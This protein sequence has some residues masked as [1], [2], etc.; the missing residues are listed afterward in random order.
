MTHT[1]VFRPAAGDI[2]TCVI[3][4]L[5]REVPEADQACVSARSIVAPL[6]AGQPSTRPEGTESAESSA[7]CGEVG[8]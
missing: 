6:Q 4:G 7:L 2:L 5:S 8:A 3:C 1:H